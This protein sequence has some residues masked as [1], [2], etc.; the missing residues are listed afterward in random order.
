M[1]NRSKRVWKIVGTTIFW[2]AVA[3]FFVAAALLRHS[4][5]EARR[6]EQVE[7]I[8][9]GRQE[10]RF[11]TPELVVG[12]IDN[13]GLNPLG[14][15]V[16]S[17]D[18]AKINHVVEEYCFVERAMTYV[19]YN[20][21]LTVELTQREPYMRIRTNSGYDFYLTRNMY[22]LPVD[23]GV[24]LRLPIATGEL[25]LPFGKS[26]TGSLREWIGEGEKK[27]K[28]S[29]NFL[30]K[31]INFVVLMEESEELSGQ[32]VQLALVMP[33]TPSRK[34][35]FQE[36]HIELVPRRGGYILEFGALENVEAKFYRWRRF[37]ESKVV[38]MS[39][40]RLNVEYDGQAIWKEEKA[41]EK[42]KKKTNKKK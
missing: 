8:I 24:A 4:N 31:L 21:T 19:D 1:S 15:A 32:F 26:F 6:V 20:G 5:E 33:R 13:A 27:S 12:L 16:D 34:G 17:L 10:A 28:E 30:C 39:R 7:V 3:G 36:P 35:E 40:G 11:V 37:C 9:A 18:L 22:V 23:A 42:T 29:Y 41:P 2:C 14:V 25:W 38:D